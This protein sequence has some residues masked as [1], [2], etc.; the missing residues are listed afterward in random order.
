MQFHLL[1]REVKNSL[2]ILDNAK[3][4]YAEQKLKHKNN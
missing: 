2:I 1:K 3:I 4:Y